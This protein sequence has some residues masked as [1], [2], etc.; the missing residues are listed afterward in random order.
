MVTY[1]LDLN[2]ISEASLEIAGLQIVGTALLAL[3]FIAAIVALV[4]Y[5]LGGLGLMRMA[6]RLG[7]KNSFFAW[8][9]VLNFYLLGKIAFGQESGL[10]WILVAL[11]P[12][13]VIP[14][15]VG[16]VFAIA[17]YV[18]LAYAGYKIFEKF[19]DKAI[20]MTVFNILTGTALS[21]VFFFAIRNNEIRD[22]A[23]VSKETTVAAKVATEAKP[24]VAVEETE[25]EEETTD[26]TEN[27]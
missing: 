27:N 7:I 22:T 11:L 15:T 5:V 1:N 20:L 24:E 4:S 21:T 18:V 23:V 13:S 6:D 2:N 9:P 16:Y 14:G 8:L 10:K 12:L 19:S 26:N 17:F 3:M 25:V